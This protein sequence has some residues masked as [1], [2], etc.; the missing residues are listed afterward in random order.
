MTKDKHAAAVSAVAVMMNPLP[1]PNIMVG[2]GSSNKST[3]T[4]NV[5]HTTIAS[6]MATACPK[7]G[8][9][10]TRYCKIT[11]ST[12]LGP[13]HAVATVRVMAK[14]TITN[15]GQSASTEKS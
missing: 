12:F 5:M 2:T 10:G 6:Q 4:P 9:G 1:K 7:C 14:V 15:T 13:Y 3:G 11:M 8:L